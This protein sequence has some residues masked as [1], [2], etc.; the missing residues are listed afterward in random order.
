MA[1]ATPKHTHALT[2][3]CLHEYLRHTRRHPAT[4]DPAADR[5]LEPLGAILGRARVGNR[6]RRLQRGWRSMELL[7]ARPR[8]LACVSLERRWNRG[9]LRS[10]S[11]SMFRAGDVERT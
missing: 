10:A 2:R 4:N 1:P 3:K 9:R 7:S 11:V 8:P 6:A 5:P